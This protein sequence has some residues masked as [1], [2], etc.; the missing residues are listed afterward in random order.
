MAESGYDS[1]LV[2]SNGTNLRAAGVCRE[3]LISHWHSGR[4]LDQHAHPA[5]RSDATVCWNR[6]I[7]RPEIRFS[8]DASR[9]R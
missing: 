6:L 4:I 7:F 9:N 2:E 5:L 8:A 3:T 1:N